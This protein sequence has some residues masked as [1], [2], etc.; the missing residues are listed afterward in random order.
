MQTLICDRCPTEIGRTKRAELIETTSG[1]G[2]HTIM[3][4][5]NNA[6]GKLTEIYYI[7]CDKCWHDFRQWL[8]IKSDGSAA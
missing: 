1:I 7:V 8:G 2:G 6:D 5:D 4:Y 3:V